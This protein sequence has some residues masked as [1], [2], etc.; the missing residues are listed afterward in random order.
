M[1][2]QVNDS[3]GLGADK[4]VLAGDSLLCHGLLQGANI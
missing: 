3:A 1:H 4:Q 2:G